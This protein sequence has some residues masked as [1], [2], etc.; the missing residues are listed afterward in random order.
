[1]IWKSTGT[2]KMLGHYF[3]GYADAIQL[4]TFTPSRAP[5]KGP[6]PPAPAETRNLNIIQRSRALV[7]KLFH[8][9][10]D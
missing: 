2:A 1:M 9:R 4:A 10:Q 3:K 5:P 8:T 6:A 7:N